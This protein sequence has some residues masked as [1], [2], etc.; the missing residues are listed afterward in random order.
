MLSGFARRADAREFIDDPVDS[1]AELLGSFRDIAFA[2][3]WFGGIGAVR[4]GLRGRQSA[5]I[6]DVGSGIADIPA[7]LREDGRTITCSDV[8]PVLVDLARRE[9]GEDARMRFTVADGSR[10]PF[11]DRAF[12]IAMCN[13]SLHHFDPASAVKLL[14]ELRRV[15]RVPLVTD[16]IRAPLTYAAVFTFSRIFSRNRLTR[17]DGPLSVRRAYTLDEA[18]SLAAQAGWQSPRARRYGVIRLVLSDDQAV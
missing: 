12:D 6:L 1:I 18:A 3:R 15:A 16:L 8:N 7:A 14:S 17:H 10:L 13:L 2:N 11:E 5:T 4:S 9:Y